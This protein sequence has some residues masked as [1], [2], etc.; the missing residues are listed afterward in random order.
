MCLLSAVTTNFFLP[1]ALMPFT[2][3]V[4]R[5]RALPART[6]RSYLPKLIFTH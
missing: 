6:P 4:R 1:L 2:F 5:T 3:T